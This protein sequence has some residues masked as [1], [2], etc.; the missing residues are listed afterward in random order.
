MPKVLLNGTWFEAVDSR[1]WYE[2]DFEAFVVARAGSIWPRWHCV[3]FCADV[4]DGDGVVKRPDLALIDFHYREWWVVEVELAHHS[5]DRHVVP[6][7]VVFRHGRYDETHAQALAQKDPALDPARLAEMMRGQPPGVLVVVDSPS[8]GWGPALQAEG[9]ELAIVEPFRDPNTQVL[10][11]VNGYQPE[12]PRESLT[13]C[14][15]SPQMRRLWRVSSP[16]TLPAA[17]DGVYLISLEGSISRWTRIDL[18]G[19][20]VLKA[21]RGDVLAGFDTVELASR[22]DGSLT[23]IPIR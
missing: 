8:T 9:T 16:A 18:H 14:V 10:L 20:V 4:A 15:R 5:L 21:E 23:F 6:Q 13:R 22:E 19:S 1:S 3:P 12:P 17:S 7:I 2:S 11:R